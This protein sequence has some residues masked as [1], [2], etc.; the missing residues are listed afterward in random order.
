[1][2]HLIKLRL[3]LWRTKEYA[4]LVKEYERDVIHIQTID[5]YSPPSNNQE[6]SYRKTVELI[7]LGQLKRAR[8]NI[9]SNGVSDPNL[10]RIIEQMRQ[11]F[12]KCKRSIPPPTDEQFN[13][14]RA[15]LDFGILKRKISS[16]KPRVAPGIGGLR[17]E[18]LTSI[19]FTDRSNASPKAKSAIHSFHEL[20]NQIVK[21]NLP[22][23]FYVA[24]TA[25]GLTAMNKTTYDELGVDELM[26]CRP[27][28]K[29]N[30]ARK[31][32]T[33]A[34]IEPFKMKMVEVT[35]PTQ[36]GSGEKAGG[37]QLIFAAKLMMEANPTFVIG[38][39][40]VENSF[41]E[42][43]RQAVLQTLWKEERLRDLW[44]YAWRC[45]E[46]KA[47]IGLGS[48]PQMEKAPFTSDEGEQ[49]GAVESMP[50]FCLGTDKP[51]NDTNDDLRKHGGA[52]MA[53]ADD[54]YL[55]GPPEIVFPLIIKHK[56]RLATV[57]L[58]LNVSKTKCYIHEDHRTI[59]YHELRGDI[60]EGYVDGNNSSKAYGIKVYGIPLGSNR[61]IREVLGQQA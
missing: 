38:S 46:C 45:K 13:H 6:A 51:N 4:T 36:F 8:T 39:I 31:V 3:S 20:G 22:W 7:R 52:L 29:G 48:G 34:W 24:W 55:I 40:D 44:Y 58:K 23:F 21:G 57:G 25:S 35:R 54:T 14:S 42:V 17:N 12:P 47:Y 49:Q 2:N 60:P 43:Q 50:F 26:D 9:V 18:H 1:M 41:N 5:D 27:L 16:L 15:N 37:T 10:P 56:E 33:S 11:K 19:V 61:Y 32:I 28:M 53:G 59:G 30:S